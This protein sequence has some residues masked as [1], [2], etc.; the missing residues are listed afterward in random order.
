MS[1]TKVANMLKK[2]TE[3][4][5]KLKVATTEAAKA[6]KT[7]AAK[8]K[9]AKATKGKKS[10]KADR[11]KSIAAC[12]KKSELML[13]TIE[14]LKTWLVAKKVEKLTGLR[15]EELVAKVLKKLKAAE[16]SDSES[17]SSDSDSDSSDSD[18]DSDSS[19]CDS[20]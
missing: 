5:K 4:L 17:D 7:K 9:P 2:L 20:D 19:D 10:K 12:S 3:D 15:K 1:S 11:P 16:E 18:S 13:F 8:A 14:E 6:T